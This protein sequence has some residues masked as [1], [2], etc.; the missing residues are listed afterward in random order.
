VGPVKNIYASGGFIRSKQW[1]TL[2]ADVLGKN[3]SV[4]HAEDS[5]AAGAA[6]LGM[7]AL[8]VIKN[9]EEVK[10][11][12]TV[13]EIFEPDMQNH[14]TYMRNYSIYSTLYEK[15]RDIKK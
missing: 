3:V 8:G 6:I 14:Q 9:L 10:S 4:T 13:K 11:F 15:F 5:S 7:Q 1:V 12:F 2:L